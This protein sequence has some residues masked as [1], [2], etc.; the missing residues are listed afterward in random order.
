MGCRSPRPTAARSRRRMSPPAEARVLPSG[1]KA[2]AQTGPCAPCGCRG[3]AGRRVPAAAPSCRIAPGDDGLAVGAEGHGI[4]SCPSDI[5][6]PM[7]WP[8]GRVPEP[9]R[10]V[11]ARR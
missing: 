1:L 7:G 6:A 11:L 5:G 10:L 8:R 3:P 4:D 2:T 9:R